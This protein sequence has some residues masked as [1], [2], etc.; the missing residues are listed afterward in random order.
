[1]WLSMYKD[2]SEMQLDIITEFFSIGVGNA[3]TSLSQLINHPVVMTVPLVETMDY[4]ELFEGIMSDES[5][6]NAAITMIHGELEGAFLFVIR[7]DEADKL[8]SLM[9]GETQG[10]HEMAASAFIELVNIIVNTFLNAISQ[11]FD[12]TVTTGIPFMIEDMFGA[13]ISSIYMEQ[14]AYEENLFIIKNEFSYLGERLDASLYFI[15]KQGVLDELLNGIT[16]E[17]EN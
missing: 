7:D 5:S 1:M 13:I 14:G 15:P 6:V 17:K 11:V 4:S 8:V 16:T 12:V 3:A 10:D 2:Y 9:L